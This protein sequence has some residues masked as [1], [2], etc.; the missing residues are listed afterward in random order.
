MNVWTNTHVARS[1]LVN[2]HPVLQQNPGVL[3]EGRRPKQ[4]HAYGA[5][6]HTLWTCLQVSVPCWMC[7]HMEAAPQHFAYV[8]ERAHK[9]QEPK[10]A[11]THVPVSVCC[12]QNRNI[13]VSA[14]CAIYE[15]MQCTDLPCSHADFSE[16]HLKCF[17]ELTHL[18]K[19]CVFT[20]VHKT[21]T[22]TQIYISVFLHPLEM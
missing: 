20:Q 6:T 11:H 19:L 16:L 13:N 22:H 3:P 18:K 14:A 4:P 2:H 12:F 8:W 10:W 21:H 9:G 7:A 1:G 5:A 17:L 15:H